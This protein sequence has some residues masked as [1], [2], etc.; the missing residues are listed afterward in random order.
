M[1]DLD[2]REIL[3]N[4]FLVIYGDLISNVPLAPAL[5]AHKKKRT[6]DKN[7][8]MTMV[9][10]QS[11]GVSNQNMETPVFICDSRS[12]RCLHYE[13]IKP[14]SDDNFLLLD[15]EVLKQPE[16]EI[17]ADLLDCGIDICTPD[18][19]ALWSDNF[20]FQTPRDN[21]LYSVLKDY[22]L[23]GKKIFTHVVDEHYV[24]RVASL[25]QYA[26]ITKDVIGRWAYPL[27]PDTNLLHYQNYHL[28]RNQ[29]YLDENLQLARSCNIKKKSIIGA[30]CRIGKNTTIINSTIG[31]HCDIGDN[32]TIED[33]F[34]WSNAVIGSNTTIKQSIVAERARICANCTL[35]PGALISFDVIIDKDITVKGTSKIT[36]AKR[37]TDPIHFSMRDV[38]LVG[39]SGIGYAY[40]PEDDEDESED[41]HLLHNSLAPSIYNLAS[42]SLSQESISVFSDESDSDSGSIANGAPTPLSMRDR[43]AASSFVSADAEHDNDDD[44][45]AAAAAARAA[46]DF[47]HEAGSS[48]LEALQKSS[49]PSTVLLELNGLRLSTNASP[50]SMR[51]AVAHAFVKHIVALVG[52]GT[53]PKDAVE[54][55]VGPHVEMWRR[56][57]FDREADEKDDQADLLLCIQ[58]ELK[59][60]NH[61]D[62]ILSLMLHQL[63]HLDVVEAE[64]VEQWWNSEK[65]ASTEEMRAVRAASQQLV[66]FLL[67]EDEEDEDDE[68]SEEE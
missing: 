3:K 12:S 15:A 2:K 63:V 54:G 40:T 24:K 22:E 62:A 65:S 34:I 10:R 60:K 33:S 14:D 27:C 52:G 49:P 17:R 31:P 4:D 30:Y 1:R 20:D 50:H 53:S 55:T 39:E 36:R 57:V 16:I 32:V 43:S 51:R 46:H 19:L 66:D 29:V 5:A 8:I 23:N 48:L 41:S 37:P 11:Y 9:L 56:I 64:G 61:G 67:E 26:A 13:S 18:F 7:C 6:E 42:L 44:P 59:A 21:F 35:E 45:G 47:H 68:E 38:K 25:Q 58:S 28:K